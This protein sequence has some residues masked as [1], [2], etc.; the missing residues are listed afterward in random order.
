MEFFFFLNELFD[1]SKHELNILYN[2]LFDSSVHKAHRNEPDPNEM[3]HN[4]IVKYLSA[5]IAYLNK[6][7][8][9]SFFYG[10]ILNLWTIG[11]PKILLF[12]IFSHIT[13]N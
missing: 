6:R 1:V 11:T 8:Q 13:I 3:T 2:P 9:F 5:I 12:N 10:L 4:S 7:N